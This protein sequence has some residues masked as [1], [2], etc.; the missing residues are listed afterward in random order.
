M[1]R[2]VFERHRLKSVVRLALLFAS[3][4][5]AASWQS[6]VDGAMAGRSGTAVV[7]SAA[8]G[9]V[10]A[11]RKAEIAATAPGSA[12]KPF[13]LAA[14]IDAGVL[15]ARADWICLGHLNIDGHN[16]ACTHPKSAAPLDAVSALAY[17]CN[18]FFAHF[19]AAIPPARLRAV[20]AGYGFEVTGAGDVRLMALGEAGVRITP[21]RMAAAYRK[22]ALAQRENRVSLQPVFRGME[23]SAVYGTARGASIEGWPIAGKTGTGP[24]YGW[25]AGYAPANHPEWVLV[26]AV[27]KG[28]GSGDAAPL[29]H[30]I[31]SRYRQVTLTGFVNVE[32]HVYALEDYVAGV[33]AGE[34][35]TYGQPQAL[36]AM[37]IAA[38]TY[39]VR[40]RGR[41]GAEGF[42]FCS[43]THCQNFKPAAVTA[44]MRE[45]VETTAGEMVWYQGAP[46]ETYYGQD[47]GG[48]TEAGGEPYLIGRADA[49]CQ[50]MGRKQWS[51]EIA[52][53]DIG[54]ALGE[55]VTT[56]EIA[57]RTGSGRAQSVRI[58]AGRVLGATD[59]RLGVG[60]A[61]GW[62]LV[63]SDLYSVT[64]RNGRAVFS[65]YGAGHGIG[66]CQ[67]GAEAMARGGASDREILATY[68]PGTAV[69]L[70][71]RALRW[72]V[73]SGERVELWSTN[74]GDTR[75]IA[76]AEPA[77][78]GAE[79]RAGWTVAR[80]VKLMIYPSV[81][82]FRNATGESGAVL[83][84]TRGTVIRAQPSIDA[85]TVRHEIWHAVIESQAPSNLPDWFREG[86]AIAMSDAGGHSAERSAALQR[87]RRLIAR[88]GEK[89][90]LAWAGGKAAPAGTFSQ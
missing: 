57:G 67:N 9:R 35:A 66:L 24:E 29:A 89:E 70:T 77:L 87:V 72:R 2:S 45:A 6:A 28:A 62:N 26:V 47:C 61:L 86:L 58:S 18:E 41:H 59:F 60:R 22:L 48:V 20:L 88:Y 85:A 64:V 44:A 34:A 7:V 21:L 83:A 82:T 63:R 51:A 36:R 13:T 27:P 40:F 31:L 81:E 25:F 3:L 4:G 76:I 69:G 11:V 75:W 73:V 38:R 1:V 54:K 14:L 19:A 43:L 10:V 46:A 39:A 16:L 50:R 68:Y 90:V 8:D 49:A 53:S 71:A 37:A 33:L 12:I 79:A 23:A 84:S 42:D 65:G 30:E 78:R 74:D 52:L 80:R 15:P 32:G 55:R 5:W 17:S 56:V